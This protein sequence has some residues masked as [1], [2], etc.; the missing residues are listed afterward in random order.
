M[1]KRLT[2]L[3]AFFL[4]LGLCFSLHAQQGPDLRDSRVSIDQLVSDFEEMTSRAETCDGSEECRLILPSWKDDVTISTVL[5]DESPYTREVVRAVEYYSL[6]LSELISHPVSM[7]DKEPN[8]FVFFVEEE[9]LDLI[10]KR[11]FGDDMGAMAVDLASISFAQ[12]ACTAVVGTRRTQGRDEILIS[13]IFLPYGLTPEAIDACVL[14]EL[15]GALGL[16]GDPAGSDSLFD[17]GNSSIDAGRIWLSRPTELM[18]TGL[19]EVSR[20]TYDS[21]RDFL[22]R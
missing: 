6:K 5:L 1:E 9:M 16:V 3:F 11:N 8:T 15:V 10:K 20:G 19:Y 4:S 12:D 22:T 14:E 2:L 21:F 18:L 17:F 7:G 13:F